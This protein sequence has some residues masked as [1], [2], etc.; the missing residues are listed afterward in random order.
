[1]KRK[2]PYLEAIYRNRWVNDIMITSSSS[3]SSCSSSIGTTTLGWVSACATVV[4][5]SQQ[6]GFT[7][8]RCQRHVKPPTWRR[9]L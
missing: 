5:H 4:E 6:E 3:S 8:F 2:R 7:D 9:I 1:M